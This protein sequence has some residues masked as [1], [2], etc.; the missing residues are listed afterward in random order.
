[1]S[2]NDGVSKDTAIVVE[3]GEEYDPEKFHISVLDCDIE[4]EIPGLCLPQPSSPSNRAASAPSPHVGRTQ[5]F[6]AHPGEQTGSLERVNDDFTRMLG[7]ALGPCRNESGS[8]QIRESDNPG[9][10]LPSPG[11][12]SINRSL[13]LGQNTFKVESPSRFHPSGR[14]FDNHIVSEPR[15]YTE[16]TR[17]LSSRSM[18]PFEVFRGVEESPTHVERKTHYR[19]TSSPIHHGTLSLDSQNTLKRP[20]NVDEPSGLQRRTLRRRGF[21]PDSGYHEQAPRRRQYSTSTSDSKSGYGPRSYSAPARPH[22][23]TASRFPTQRPLARN[24]LAKATTS[25]L[26]IEALK[27]RQKMDMDTQLN[28]IPVISSSSSN[29]QS[30]RA[31]FTSSSSSSSESEAGPGN[32]AKITNSA[33]YGDEKSDMDMDTTSEEDAGFVNTVKMNNSPDSCATVR[34]EDENM[35]MDTTSEEEAGPVNAVEVKNS[36]NSC[37]MAQYEDE[38]SD[39]DTTSE[40]EDTTSEEED[41]LSPDSAGS[42]FKRL[43]TSNADGQDRSRTREEDSRMVGTGK[44]RRDGNRATHVDRKGKGGEIEI[45][46]GRS[47]PSPYLLPIPPSPCKIPKVPGVRARRVLSPGP[48]STTEYPL[49][50]VSIKGDLQFINRKTRRWH[51]PFS[52]PNDDNIPLR[53]EDACIVEDILVVAYNRGSY[54]LSTLRLPPVSSDSKRPK[55]LYASPSPESQGIRSLAPAI[56]SSGRKYAITADFN[57]TVRMWDVEVFPEDSSESEDSEE[58]DESPHPKAKVGAR[59]AKIG[60]LPYRATALAVRGYELL[61]SRGKVLGMGDFRQLPGRQTCLTDGKPDST[62]SE[63]ELANEITHIHVPLGQGKKDLVII[64]TN[65]PRTQIGIYDTRKNIRVDGEDISFGYA[66]GSTNSSPQQTT[67]K[68][69][70]RYFRGGPDAFDSPETYKFVRG[71]S[72]GVVCLFDLRNA[73]S[74]VRI[75]ACRDT[76]N[77]LNKA[78][79]HTIF[80]N[81]CVDDSTKPASASS[82]MKRYSSRGSGRSGSSSSPSKAKTVKGIV[83]FGGNEVDFLDQNLASY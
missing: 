83:T 19:A 28:R 67:Q 51:G 76:S 13:G 53:V 39:A 23:P 59:P 35:D 54:Q 5:D 18:H 32:N 20:R 12:S 30:Q 48:T 50:T 31:R 22:H 78:V 80:A 38:E 49:A 58:E 74:P 34:Y 56:S 77:K 27:L 65:H 79:Y 16:L 36:A 52:V 24:E 64:E 7:E 42:H 15:H 17:D 14:S 68:T 70:L 25:E 44:A 75:S 37:A 72:D 57:K 4:M 45:I 55:I 61:Y 46:L 8:T 81:F 63:R 21:V 82:S 29:S 3:S 9:I 40:E 66:P 26:N 47:L 1:M 10:Y 33:S 43:K 62:L 6:K 69:S 2:E 71:Y 73:R 11:P 41:R 60:V